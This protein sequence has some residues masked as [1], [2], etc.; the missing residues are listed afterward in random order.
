MNVLFVTAEAA[1]LIKVG[2]LGDVAGSLPKALR[3]RGH[4]VRLILPQYGSINVAAVGAT[5]IR[6]AVPVRFGERTLVVDLLVGALPGSDIPLYLLR[7][8]E[9]FGS[10]GVYY[11][12]TGPDARRHE[13]QRFVFFSL[14]VSQVFF[15]LGWQPDIVH[16]HDWHTALVPSLLRTWSPRHTRLATVLTIHNLQNQGQ[17]PRPDILSWVGPPPLHHPAF[18]VQPPDQIFNCLREGIYAAA[19]VN[20]VSP[21]YAQEI[22][23]P[24][25]GDGLDGPL[26]QRLGGVVGILN[27]LDVEA[28]NPA[29]DKR[30]VAPYT[31][32]SVPS[33]KSANKAALQHE[34]GLPV[35]QKKL[36]I[37]VVSRLTEQK[38]LDLLRS[39]AAECGKLNI[40]IVILGTGQPEIEQALQDMMT[41]Y[42]QSMVLMKKFDAV[43]AQHIYGGADAFLMPSR[44]EPCGLGQMVAMRYGALPIVRDTGGLHDTV[45]DLSTDPAHGNG[46][47]F[48]AASPDALLACLG[49]AVQL[50]HQPLQWQQAV[51]RAMRQ[52][53][54]WTASAASYERLYAE[55]IAKNP[56]A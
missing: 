32:D 35:D 26:R 28:F 23:R 41:A 20:T 8:P 37:G 36:L 16:C 5:V 24:E 3:Q 42:P 52:D 45:V 21:T 47:V 56:A 9:F 14:A 55:A 29:T 31:V 1:P 10:G 50:W 40:Q 19:T 34:V 27:G 7:C 30:L 11:E 46:F 51:Q 43:L 49:R 39:S 4:D 44:F 6:P 38:G 12:Q 33:G 22:I 2:G 48:R 54:S 15:Q 53:F 25:L 13:V 18:P 17:W